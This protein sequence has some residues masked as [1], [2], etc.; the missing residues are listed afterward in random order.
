VKKN[1]MF[2][3]IAAFLAALF[4]SAAAGCAPD[5]GPVEDPDEDPAKENETEIPEPVNDEVEVEDPEPAANYF[6][7][8]ISHGQLVLSSTEVIDGPHLF[9]SDPG[10]VGEFSRDTDYSGRVVWLV[11]QTDVFEIEW[12]TLTFDV[13]YYAMHEWDLELNFIFELEDLDPVPEDEGE[14]IFEVSLAEEQEGFRVEIDRL[15]LGKEQEGSFTAAPI[16]YV[17]LEI[18]L[19]VVDKP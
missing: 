12:V 11:D 16:D 2:I 6:W 14:Q 19:T 1:S 4:L 3:L 15:I 17:A 10:F 7:P 18:E 5:P 8:W 13:D 9:E